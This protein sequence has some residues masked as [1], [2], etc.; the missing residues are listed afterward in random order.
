MH[1]HKVIGTHTIFVGRIIAT[2]LCLHRP[3]FRRRFYRVASQDS[4]ASA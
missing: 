1:D 3:R 2:R 4:T